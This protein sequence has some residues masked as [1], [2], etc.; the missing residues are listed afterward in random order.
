MLSGLGDLGY[1]ALIS[2]EPDLPLLI[3]CV[4][5]YQGLEDSVLHLTIG[6]SAGETLVRIVGGTHP[7]LVC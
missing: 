7:W 6:L 1:L 2:V 3:F 4:G 5:H